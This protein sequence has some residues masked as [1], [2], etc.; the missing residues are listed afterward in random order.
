[1]SI[2]GYQCKKDIITDCRCDECRPSILTQLSSEQ[3]ER[4]TNPEEYLRKKLEHLYNIIE[5]SKSCISL[6]DKAFEDTGNDYSHLLRFQMA[7]SLK[8]EIERLEKNNED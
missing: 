4:V 3:Y 2:Q 8:E 1:M 7:T 5:L 6:Y